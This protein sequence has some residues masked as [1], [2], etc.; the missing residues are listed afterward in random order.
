[1]PQAQKSAFV[2]ALEGNA[3]KQSP[4]KRS[5]ALPHRTAIAQ[6]GRAGIRVTCPFG[7]QCLPQ[8]IATKLYEFLS[9]IE[10]YLI[11]K[12]VKAPSRRT[13]VFLIGVEA[14][15]PNSQLDEV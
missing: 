9:N 5:G 10:I 4:E 12:K 3:A 8:A 15:V 13:G 14:L 1:M 7:T 6:R 11:R 2:R